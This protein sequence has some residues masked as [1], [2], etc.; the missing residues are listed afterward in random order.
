[1]KNNPLNRRFVAINRI[2]ESGPNEKF[3]PVVFLDGCNL[4]CP[5]CLNESI[6][7]LSGTPEYIPAHE[8]L[9]HLEIW[10][11]E[12]CMISGGEPCVPHTDC[13]IKDVVKFLSKVSK[14][15]GIATN[16]SF[17]QILKSLIDEKLVSYVALDCKFSPVS[18]NR[19]FKSNSI[20][21][22][23]DFCL[24]VKESLDLLKQ[25]HTENS[26][27]MSEVR[28]TVYPGLIEEDDIV[29]IGKLVHE[30]SVWV[31]QQYRQHAAFGSDPVVPYA[32]ERLMSLHQLAKASCSSNV[33]LR[34]P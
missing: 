24:K 15:I 4:R 10:G 6:V 3:W 1:M 23:S 19:C 30:K 14:Q 5:Y 11:E 26:N 18:S 32:K 31:L 20:Q 28:T 7:Q 13:D 34:W 33:L 12:G 27:A 25:W 17:P 21:A 2:S 9:G 29:E 16:G 8:I 22:K